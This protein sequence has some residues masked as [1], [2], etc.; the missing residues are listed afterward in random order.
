M[1]I[2]T[3]FLQLAKLTKA[4]RLLIKKFKIFNSCRRHLRTSTKTSWCL[5]QY[6]SVSKKRNFY[7]Q[8]KVP[9]AMEI[10]LQAVMNQNV[11][12]EVIGLGQNQNQAQNQEKDPPWSKWMN[13]KKRT[14][15]KTFTQIQLLYQSSQIWIL[16]V[17]YKCKVQN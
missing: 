7:S 5:E 17:Y 4:L 3:T 2:F 6:R 13:F 15:L 1:E 9:A 16:H 11:A 12:Q 10:Q 8:I 14:V